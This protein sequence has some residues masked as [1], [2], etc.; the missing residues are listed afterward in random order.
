MHIQSGVLDL[1]LDDDLKEWHPE[2]HFIVTALTFLK[3]VF[4]M[5]SFQQFPK[6]A[7]EK[8]KEL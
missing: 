2:R 8:A 5:K 3:K 1:K 4:Y 6:V 7:D